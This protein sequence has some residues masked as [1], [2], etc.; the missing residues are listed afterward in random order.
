MKSNL[1]LSPMISFSRTALLQI[2]TILGLMASVGLPLSAV[3]TTNGH[4][5]TRSLVEVEGHSNCATL[6]GARAGIE[7]R[8]RMSLSASA[9]N[10]GGDTYDIHHYHFNLAL[11]NTSTAIAGDVMFR[12]TVTSP[13]MDTFWFELRS[14]MNID[15]VQING[16]RYLPSALSRLND[17]VRV[18][19]LSNLD[20]G[21]QVTCR[22]FYQGTPPSGGFFSG[23]SSA[24]SPT[25]GVNVTWTLSEPFSAPDWFPCKQDL[26][27][28]IDSVFFDGTS[29]APNKVAS[30][31][32]LIGVD[33]LTNNRRKYKWRS[34]IP[35]AFYLMAFSVTDYIEHLSWAHPTA[36]ANDSV[37][38][39]HW[40]Y[41]ANNSSGTSCL[42][43]N[44]TALN[45]TGAMI[46]NFSDLFILYPFHTE[47]YGHMMAPLGGGME[48]Q[49]MST[50][51]SFGMDLIAHEL[52][53]QWFGDMVTCATW[54]DIWLNEGWASYGEYL[55]RQYVVSQTSAS[56][57]MNSTHNSARS[58]T[59][60]SVYVPASGVTNVNR[61]FSS[62]LTYKKGA[63]VLHMLRNEIGDDSLFFPAV[64]E[65]LQAKRH[66]VATT[67]EFR[68]IMEQRTSVPLQ[69]FF[70]DWIYGEGHP[71]YNIQWNWRDSVL[72]LQMSQTVTA[73]A[74][75]PVFRNKLPLGLITSGPGQAPTLIQVEPALGLQRIR[76]PRQVAN[77]TLDPSNAI[78]KGTTSSISR[79]A[80][81]GVGLEEL[82]VMNFNPYPNPV[83]GILQVDLNSAAEL[84][85]TDI[86]GRQMNIFHGHEG[87]NQLDLNLPSGTYFLQA[88]FPTGLRVSR[89]IVIP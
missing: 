77:V 62:S 37:L 33:T 28:K 35:M 70:Q 23:V 79:L 56:D 12:S 17:V 69:N 43:F 66:S 55:H 26:W 67:D 18:P 72:W 27:D 11:T 57:W 71:T 1:F 65:Y 41:N 45:S 78:L 54:N 84:L 3:A 9:M 61:I 73:P 80:T 81:L 8:N 64:R 74:A 14:L 24:V 32:L 58:S 89:R 21:M 42:N 44:R 83:Q 48:H 20:A 4:G 53:H 39:Q 49:T 31:G 46:E 82:N 10:R 7:M 75:T 36:L 51:G 86:S 2:T 34:R 19:L 40:I 76:I 59:T 15:S 16:T 68:Q 5:E 87:Q 52:A 29:V 85:L 13:V 88:L 30:T 63:A 47:K 22:V 50:M 38:I 25:W 60:G 6:K